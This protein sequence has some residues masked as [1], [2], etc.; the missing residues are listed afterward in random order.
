MKKCLL[1]FLLFFLIAL[2]ANSQQ[3]KNVILEQHTGAWCGW[4]V[5]GTYV[6]DLLLEDYPERVIGVKVH[7]GDNMVVP[8]QATIAGDLGLTGYPNG[9]VDRKDY[10]GGV[11]ISRGAWTTT[12]EQALEEIPKVT[13]NVFYTINPDTR[14]LTATI[15]ATILEEISE[16]LSFNVWVCEDSVSGTGTGWDQS[17]Y[18]S[19]RAGYEDNPYYNEPSTIVG[20]QHM[21]CLRAFLGGA[22]GIE[23]EFANKP[24][25]VGNTYSHEFTHIIPLEWKIEHIWLAGIVSVNE[26]NNKEILNCCYG[27]TKAPAMELTSDDPDQGIVNSGETFTKTFDVKNISDIEH[28]FTVTINVSD[29]TPEDWSFELDKTELTVA[30]GETGSFQA[31]VTLGETLS[32][33][34]AKIT[35]TSTT[36]PEVPRVYGTISAISR[37]IE[38][39]EVINDNEIDNS[40]L[41]LCS[42]GMQF[43]Q[44]PSNDFSKYFDV[45][46]NLKSVIW[47]LGEKGE[48]S[49]TEANSVAGLA[50]NDVNV[51]LLGYNVFPSLNDAE[52]LDDLGLEYFGYSKEGDQGY[53]DCWSK[54]NSVDDDPLFGELMKSKILS[55]KRMT[56]ELHVVK[57]TD[58]ENVF[59]VITFRDEQEIFWDNNGNLETTNVEGNEAIAGV[60]LI[61]G[62]SKFV[63]L[64]FNPYGMLM[65][66]YWD[67]F[68]NRPLEWFAGTI[69]VE[70]TIENDNFSLTVSPNPIETATTVNYVINGDSPQQ[71]RLSLF[72][73]LG[74]EVALISGGTVNPGSHTLSYSAGNLANGIYYMVLRSGV[75]VVSMPIVIL[76]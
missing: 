66:V 75:E 71:V 38:Y 16:N 46:P 33:G 52:V 12:V 53:E 44:I 48:M 74:Q 4:C 57:I 55:L 27:G 58:A 18:L 37:D 73:E 61:K 23:G 54:M 34:E 67:D 25:I 60:R 40:V 45:L 51:L 7:N 59:P 56:P 62:N 65:E 24:Y 9:N 6:M 64:G 21:K 63:I 39:F 20:Y 42:E 50:D 26:T 70:K 30:A 10:G 11:F 69:D 5:D 49:V 28:N 19:G 1:P 43:I 72:N 22:W 3:V 36:D 41:P 2:T 13:V 32:F 29:K 15:N 14:E 8:E 76:K 31:L 35:V 17:N 68:V 47:N